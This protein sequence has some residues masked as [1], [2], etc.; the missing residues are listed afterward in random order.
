[1]GGAPLCL[2][3]F[4]RAPA[5]RGAP[6]QTI[7]HGEDVEIHA[8]RMQGWSISAIARHTGRDRKTV[9]A[10]LSGDRAEGC[11]PDAAASGASPYQANRPCS[12]PIPSPVWPRRR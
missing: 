7:T 12:W 10:Y 5:T 8:L 1:M 9:R 2:P 11:A 3:T 4:A 6:A